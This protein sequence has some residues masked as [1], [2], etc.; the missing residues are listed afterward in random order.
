MRMICLMENTSRKNLYTEHGLSL[1]LETRE[2]KIL[3]DM[4]QSDLFLRNAQRL[5]V[6]LSAVDLAV[7]SHGH[8]DHGGGLETFLS[9]NDHAFVYMHGSALEQYCAGPDRGIG[10][11]PKF[12]GHPQ[13]LMTGDEATLDEGLMLF[14]G[15]HK[16]KPYSTDSDGFTVFRDGVAALDDFRHEQ[17]LLI[18]D[19]DKTYLISGCSHKGIQNVMYWMRPCPPDVVVGGFHISKVPVDE[20]GKQRLDEL[21]GTLLEYP[22]VYYTCHCTGIQQYQY[23]KTH[24]QDRLEYL[25]A[26]DER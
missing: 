15:N 14:T 3:F 11:D 21:A 5:N 16:P 10:L 2:H 6:D 20:T 12:Q 22:S 25:S 26:G 9:V 7:I 23:L 18:K 4:G 13:I 24:L 1:Y 19:E 8:Y 17:Y